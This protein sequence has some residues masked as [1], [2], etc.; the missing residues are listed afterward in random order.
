MKETSGLCKEQF[1]ISE[2][3]SQE[4]CKACYGKKTYSVFEWP[5]VIEP[6]FSWDKPVILNKWGIKEYSCKRCGGEGTEPTTPVSV[7]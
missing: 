4:K 6:D 2:R 5:Q 3:V 1:W 7:S